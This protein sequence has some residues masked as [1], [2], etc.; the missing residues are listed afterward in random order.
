MSSTEYPIEEYKH[1]S[2]REWRPDEQPRE[3]MMLLGSKSLSDSELLAIFIGGGTR[4]E[5]A[6][7]LAKKLLDKYNSLTEL[8]GCDLSQFKQIK[9]IGDAKAVTIAAAFEI[10]KRIK[11]IPLSK[12]KPIRSAQDIADYFIPKFLGI[13]K[14]MFYVL[15]LNTAGKIF[16]EHL[17]SEGLLNASLVH[18][19]EVFKIAIT[20]SAASVILLHNHPSGNLTP[21]GNDKNI[22]KQLK[23]A[24]EIIGIKVLD[25]IIIGGDSYFSFTDNGIM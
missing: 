5:S 15:L 18:P 4:G 14:E 11:I 17:V 24:G 23:D 21:S 16:R 6:I 1:K 20:E 9:G 25:H 8:A 3:K 13:K 2:I 19:R 22:T 10:A 12:N 7:D